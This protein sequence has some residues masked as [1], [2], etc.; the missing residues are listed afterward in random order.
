MLLVLMLT[1]KKLKYFIL[2]PWIDNDYFYL[3]NH[4]DL[5]QHILYLSC[6]YFIFICLSDSIIRPI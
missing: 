2:D 1:G 6:T 5:V 4:F 3:S